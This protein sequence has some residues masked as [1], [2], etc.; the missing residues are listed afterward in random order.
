MA[1]DV[2]RG[3]SDLY[4]EMR[5]MSQTDRDYGIYFDTKLPTSLYKNM[6]DRVI[7]YV[8]KTLSCFYEEEFVLCDD[9]LDRYKEEILNLPNRTENG[10]FHPKRDNIVEYNAL[11]KS[12][13]ET[14]QQSGILDNCLA[15]QPCTIRVVSGAKNSVDH[16]R[17]LATTKLHSDAWASHVG[18]AIIAVPLTGD[19]TTTVEFFEPQGLTDDFFLPL[20]NY[21]DGLKKFKDKKLIGYARMGYLSVFDQACVHRTV[22][23]DGGMRVSIDFGIIVDNE[24]SLFHDASKREKKH[25]E[26]YRYEYLDKE[27]YRE[28]GKS[29]FLL[30]EETLEESM[31]RYSN[32]KLENMKF[33]ERAPIKIVEN[34]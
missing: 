18:D 26:N 14:L 17:P 7:D 34:L 10:V 27:V 4:S 24:K 25:L 23:N 1:D 19:P 30:I 9:F 13:V 29:L 12:V 16:S 3:R 32:P 21:D 2:V 15:L 31:I 11:Q 33:Y 20:K 8:F 28:L 5:S 6:V 22:L